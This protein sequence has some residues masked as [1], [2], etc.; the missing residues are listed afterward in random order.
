MGIVKK[1]TLYFLRKVAAGSEQGYT[2]PPHLCALRALAV[3]TPIHYFTHG[4]TLAYRTY[5]HGPVPLLAFHGFGRSGTDFAILK[6]AIGEHFTVHAF[7]LH[8]HGKS[9][10]YPERADRPFTPKELAVYFTAFA[11]HLG[12]GKVALLGYSLGGRIALSL[13][14]TMP[15][16]VERVFL[17]AP[18]GLITHPWYRGLAASS[19]GRT[20]YRRFVERPGIVH[21]IMN[22]LRSVRLM[23]ERMHRFLIGQTDSK[24]KRML[25]RDV[26]LCFRLIEPDLTQVAA[27]VRENAVPVHLFFG[28]H[29]RVIKP[30]FGEHL[31]KHAPELITQTDLPFGHVL[32]T[33]E[34]GAAISS[35][36]TS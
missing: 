8:F 7:D 5:G 6:D 25:V 4:V 27:Q 36:L 33:P 10:G 12:S 11:D 2:G 15:H 32:L 22:G 19:V 9:P 17:A 1:C 21:A 26:W 13:L 14:E 23:N 28:T 29:D 18:D 35:H 16:R 31:R 3:K 34:L 20:L 30:A 24:P